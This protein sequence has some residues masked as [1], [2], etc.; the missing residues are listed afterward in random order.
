M[1][2]G[3]TKNKVERPSERRYTKW[4]TE[5]VDIRYKRNAYWRIKTNGEG[6][7]IR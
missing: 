6:F 1:T 5:I 4:S 2:K 7:I 3:K